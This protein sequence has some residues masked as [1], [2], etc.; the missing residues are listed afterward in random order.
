M[1]RE[2][3]LVIDVSAVHDIDASGFDGQDIEYTHV[4]HLAVGDVDERWDRAAQIE[5]RAQ[6]DGGLGRAERRPVEKAQA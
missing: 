5:Q 3:P 1:Q 6:L 2:K 4:G